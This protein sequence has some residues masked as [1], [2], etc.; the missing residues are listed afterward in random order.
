MIGL[1]EK[2]DNVGTKPIFRFEFDKGG[3]KNRSPHTYEL[4]KNK[5]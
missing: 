2:L 5:K 4:V 3:E 1:I